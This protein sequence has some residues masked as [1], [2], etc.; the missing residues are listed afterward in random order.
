M[1][2]GVEKQTDDGTP[3][4]S[5]LAGGSR[6][7]EPNEIL[8]QNDFLQAVQDHT[9]GLGLLRIGQGST[10]DHDKAFQVLDRARQSTSLPTIGTDIV[11]ALNRGQ[12]LGH[13]RNAL[14]NHF[15]SNNWKLDESIAELAGKGG[16]ASPSILTNSDAATIIANNAHFDTIKSREDEVASIFPDTYS[17]VFKEE[18]K[19]QDAKP[20]WHSFPKFLRDQQETIYWIT[21][22]PGS[23]KSYLPCQT[24]ACPVTPS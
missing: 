10:T 13:V 14:I 1:L 11:E 12:M 4:M 3:Q 15:W 20:M 18:P 24:R 21:G 7:Q 16:N 17:W 6:V 23:G 19:T 22:K 2:R 8:P 9:N 5:A